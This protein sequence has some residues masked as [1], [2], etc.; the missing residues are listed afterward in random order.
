MPEYVTQRER[1][2]KSSPV[3]VAHST[4]THA[5]WG[6][7]EFRRPRVISRAIEALSGAL[8]PALKDLIAQCSPSDYTFVDSNEYQVQKSVWKMENT[9]GLQLDKARG[10]IQ[11]MK[12]GPG[13]SPH[14]STPAGFL[15]TLGNF[16]LPHTPC[17]PSRSLLRNLLLL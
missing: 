4:E 16:P 3:A 12:H 8:R 6:V 13:K 11:V 7:T 15:I 10:L 5:G 2:C 9:A 1:S 14:R 17:P